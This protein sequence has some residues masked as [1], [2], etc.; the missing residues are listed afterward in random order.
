MS[1]FP[2]EVV[3][4]VLN[5]AVWEIHSRFKLMPESV[6]GVLGHA[7]FLGRMKASFSHSKTFELSEIK[8]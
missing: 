8:I 7:G 5:S 6:P 3:L 4:P 2:I 1:V